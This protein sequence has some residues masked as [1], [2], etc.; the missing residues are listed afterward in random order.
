PRPFV[1]ATLPGDVAAVTAALRSFFNDGLAPPPR[2]ERFP[3]GDRL[4]ELL[5]FP[6][7]VPPGYG[8]IPLP[9]DALIRANT[10]DD[11]AIRR[12]LELPLERRKH[13]L[14]LYRPLDVFWF[15]EYQVRGKPA[16]FT[17]HFILHLEPDGPGRTRLEVLE[18]RPMVK[19][20]RKFGLVPHSVGPGSMS[21]LRLVPPTTRDR[22]ELLE[23]IRKA[24]TSPRE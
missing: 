12:Y 22:V 4:R 1:E 13:D 21:D 7:E 24:L 2:P 3:P 6:R 8:F 16:P 19:A 14:F 17:C 10:V 5:L 20:G 11:P 18:Y 15:S 23:R 9:E